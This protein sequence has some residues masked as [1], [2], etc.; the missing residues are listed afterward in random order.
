MGCA[1]YGLVDDGTSVS[2]GR[3]NAGMLTRGVRLPPRG[4]G[5]WV[6]P[7]WVDR[8][9]LYGT[10]EAVALVVRV[11]R[12][13][14]REQPNGPPLGV[15]DLSP[16]G[17]GPSRFHRSHQS[18]R[19]IDLLFYLVD[20]TGR[21]VRNGEMRPVDADGHTRD[22][23]RFDTAR[24]WALVR[25]LIDDPAADVQYIFVAEP[26]RLLLLD[27]ARAAGEPPDRVARAAAL[28][29][30]PSD[31]APH[32]DHFHV[33]IYCAPSD[34]P[35]GCSD[36]GPLRWK[37]KL[38]KYELVAAEP[39][40]AGAHGRAVR[41]PAAGAPVGFAF[42]RLTRAWSLAFPPPLPGPPRTSAAR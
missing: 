35:L 24:N 15:A 26:L 2:F 5:Y 12:R 39:A 16:R 22:G 19:D 14:R 41:R 30:Q 20:A 31:A 9:A 13:L 11:A 32:D 40:P 27:H 38:Y 29:R 25:A 42:G 23:L 6:P 8:G 21:P 7:R 18:G 1:Q 28:L 10:D 36:R 3:G 17:G 4:D 34:R 33:R 37:K